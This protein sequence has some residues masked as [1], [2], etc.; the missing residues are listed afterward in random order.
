MG[1]KCSQ[2]VSTFEEKKQTI[3]QPC[4]GRKIYFSIETTV[5][6]VG[7][8]QGRSQK[9]NTTAHELLSRSTL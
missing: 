1:L 6:D 8:N 2:L 9:S 4:R 5:N 3:N 7:D